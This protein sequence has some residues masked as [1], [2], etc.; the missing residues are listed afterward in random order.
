[1]CDSHIQ[2]IG[3]W[4]GLH[5]RDILVSTLSECEVSSQRTLAADWLIVWLVISFMHYLESTLSL[6]T[7]FR[8]K[9]KNRRKC[10]KS[11]GN[12]CDR[13]YYLVNKYENRILILGLYQVP[14]TGNKNR[15]KLDNRIETQNSSDMILS[16]SITIYFCCWTNRGNGWER[17]TLVFWFSLGLL[18]VDQFPKI[19]HLETHQESNEGK[20]TFIVTTG[21]IILIPNTGCFLRLVPP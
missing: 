12:S 20:V 3:L 14:F 2:H 21:Q 8:T 16:A 17:R 9:A 10:L 13:L 11:F 19:I 6:Q 7:N 4:Q 1:M 5:S 18:K 15:T